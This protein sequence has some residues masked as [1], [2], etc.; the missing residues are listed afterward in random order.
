MV[1]KVAIVT[2]TFL[3]QIN[4]VTNSVLRLLEFC[5]EE[6]HE[7]LIIAPESP[8]APAQYLGFRV[9]HVP[10][11]SMKK[12]IPMGLPRK[13]LEPLLEGF[14]PDIIHLA[15]PIFLGHYVAKIG[16]R[17]GIPT[18]SVYQTD[19]AGFARHYG[20]T[21]AHSTLWRWISKIHQN[22]D[23]T[24]APSNWSCRALAVNGV[25]NVRLW[26]R[27]VDTQRFNP[28]RRDAELHKK[29]SIDSSKLVVGYVGRLANEKRIEDLAILDRQKD[30]QL[31]IV[32]DGPARSKLERVLPQAKFVGLQGGNQL[33]TYVAS[34][35]LFIHT[36]KHETFCQSIQEALASGVIV[37]APNT[38]GP[39]DLINHGLTGLLIDTAN[40]EE[41]LSA[42]KAIRGSKSFHTMKIAA[43]KSVEH[44][45]WDYINHQLMAFY[46]EA[47]LIKTREEEVA[48]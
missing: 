27:G 43:R 19:I 20:L 1:M 14:A 32:G 26:K 42:V 10:S 16:K 21:V 36:G 37:I 34:F 24:L 23:I 12:L 6:G 29:L 45:T 9:K 35:D 18:V 2:E 7:A 33:A 28:E 30:I 39:V 3:P 47:I 25:D 17:M 40:P 38:G 11:I 48:A 41:L 8:G 22:T 5:R 13:Y 44:R 46:R 31:V 4:G 15:S